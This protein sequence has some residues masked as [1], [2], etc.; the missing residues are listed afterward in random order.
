MQHEAR[1]GGA[2]RRSGA[3]WAAALALSLAMPGLAACTPSKPPVTPPTTTS[4]PKPSAAPSPV[5]QPDPPPDLDPSEPLLTAA[6]LRWADGSE[7]DGIALDTGTARRASPGALTVL[8]EIKAEKGRSLNILDIGADGAALVSEHREPEY[9]DDGSVVPGSVVSSVVRVVDGR[10]D[11]VLVSGAKHPEEVSLGLLARDGSAVWIASETR[12][13][14]TVEYV[15]RYRAPAGSAR[16]VETD[17]PGDIVGMLDNG[18]VLSDGTFFSWDGTTR[19]LGLPAI[20]SG[21]VLPVVCERDTC[22]LVVTEVDASDGLASVDDP[23]GAGPRTVVSYLEDGALTPVL[24]LEGMAWVVAAYERWL[25]V[26]VYG[27]DF[28]SHVWLVDTENGRARYLVDAPA[29]ALAG[30]R[31]VWGT[32]PSWSADDGGA[33]S[34]TGDLHVLDL[35]TGD[36]VRIILGEDVVRPVAE[37][38][39]LAWSRSNADGSVGRTGIVARLATDLS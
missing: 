3:A 4:S 37:G 16:G 28:S 12:E 32:S 8:R 29:V 33:L 10:H 38:D 18:A 5:P 34:G 1:R 6:V 17:V 25:V 2:A 20:S 26:D 14:S 35:A 23:T 27:G 13:T 30:S 9:R 31:V 36:L 21:S 39:T 7:V 24:R 22:P 15:H 11:R 19:D